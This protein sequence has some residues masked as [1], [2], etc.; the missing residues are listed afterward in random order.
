MTAESLRFSSFPFHLINFECLK[1]PVKT[2]SACLG[3]CCLESTNAILKKKKWKCTS[4]VAFIFQGCNFRETL[5]KHWN[6]WTQRQQGHD[7]D[8]S[9]LE[10]ETRT[11]ITQISIKVEKSLSGLLFSPYRLQDPRG[12]MCQDGWGLNRLTHCGWIQTARESWLRTIIRQ[13]LQL[14]LLA[15]PC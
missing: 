12:K 6:C 9:K 5:K 11:V 15:F 7:P 13:T 2:K 3:H 14:V 4:P 10:Q 1:T 8:S